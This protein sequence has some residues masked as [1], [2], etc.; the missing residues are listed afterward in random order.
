ML[1][2]RQGFTLA[3]LMIATAA[4]LIVGGAV[5]RML[6]SAQRLSR[7][8]AD[9][10]TLQASVRGAVLAVTNELRELST[11]ANAGGAQNDLLSIAPGEV[12]YRAM[13]GTGF[14]CETAAP[15]Q[16]RISRN[17]FTGHRTPQ[18]GRDSVLVLH[19][20]E[21][22]TATAWVT[23]PIIGVS[24][25]SSCPGIGNPSI[26][27]T[28]PVNDSVVGAAAGTPVRI[29]EIMQLRR[30]ES[31]GKSWLGMRSVS[32]GEAI[33]PLFGPVSPD[34]GF[35]LEYFDSAGAST[36][37]PRAVRSIRVAVRGEHDGRHVVEDMDGQRG[38]L[39]LH[40][41]LV[42]RNALY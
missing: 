9:Q 20:P 18:A 24:G 27:L 21:V 31:G 14:T 42:L 7:A 32:T 4:M 23:L 17:R 19:D 34:N 1:S 16:I 38:E 39:E 3:E 36:S 41:Q 10:L 8:Q 2:R 29:Y 11:R 33:Q 6:Q 25:A 5:Q 22:D 37:S 28:V 12:T 26:T 35:R 30:Y 40:T 15:G 13:R